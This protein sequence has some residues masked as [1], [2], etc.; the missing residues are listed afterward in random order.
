MTKLQK[1]LIFVQFYFFSKNREQ[2]PPS[3]LF[4]V[5][6]QS[7]NDPLRFK[8]ILLHLQY[9]S[10]AWSKT[11]SLPFTDFSKVIWYFYK[12]KLKGFLRI[13]FVLLPILISFYVTT[14]RMHRLCF[15]IIFW[16]NEVD[17]CGFISIYQIVYHMMQNGLLFLWNYSIDY[18]FSSPSLC[19]SSK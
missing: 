4:G 12:N 6:A 19:L 1:K 3:V 11:K 14:F 2:E 9:N 10:S 13:S 16:E 8:L 17:F 5:T 15:G 18:N 7:I